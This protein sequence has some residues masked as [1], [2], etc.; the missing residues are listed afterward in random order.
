MEEKRNETTASVAAGGRNTIGPP[1]GSQLG[2]QSLDRSLAGGF[3]DEWRSQR[4]RAQPLHVDGR[5]VVFSLR[6]T[7]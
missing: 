1:T 7:S 3:R 4:G 5:S 2:G 6:G